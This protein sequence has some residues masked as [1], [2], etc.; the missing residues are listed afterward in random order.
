MNKPLETDEPIVKPPQKEDTPQ[1]TPQDTPKNSSI[2]E[3]SGR[4]IIDK[5]FELTGEKIT[6]GPKSKQRIIKKAMQILTEKGI[7][8]KN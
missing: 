7:A 2:F 3:L 6:I 1:D 8:I 5:V 4:K